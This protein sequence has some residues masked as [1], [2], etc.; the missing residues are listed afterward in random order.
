MSEEKVKIDAK[1]FTSTLFRSLK[2]YVA[3]AARM[4]YN[5]AMYR[6]IYNLLYNLKV[7]ENQQ[8]F[9]ISECK[10]P[11]P[12]L[13]YNYNVDRA[14]VSPRFDKPEPWDSDSIHDPLLTKE[15]LDA[16]LD[17]FLQQRQDKN[18]CLYISKVEE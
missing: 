7:E 15:D 3:P 18:V 1:H 6:E 2:E 10:I 13:G 17:E 11:T 12:G 4:K 16:D 9:L 5:Q 8:A 14:L